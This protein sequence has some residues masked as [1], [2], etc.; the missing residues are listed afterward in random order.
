M[1]E[2]PILGTRALNRA[3]L[4]RQHLLE[5]AT[6]TLEDV[7][8][9][10]GGLQ[11]QQARSGYIGAWT[12]LAGLRRAD[13]TAALNERRLVQ[14]WL[15][16]VTIHTVAAAEYW[17]MAVAVRR[18]RRAW[19][20]RA[21]GKS[22]SEADLRRAAAAVRTELADG[23]L[24]QKQLVARMAERWYPREVT[25][26]AGLWVD[27]VR[28]PPQGTWERPR[29]DLYGLAE[30]W[31]P[32][33]DIAE[34]DARDLLLRRFLGAYGPAAVADASGWTG[35][36]VSEL[37]P[38]VERA[39]LRRF[40]DE[41]GRELLDLPDAQVPDPETPAP[42][43]FIGSFD[44][45]LLIQARRTGVLPEEFRGVVYNTGAPQSFHTF[46]LDGQV[47]GSWRYA[48]G[49]VELTP[50]RSLG[51]AERRELEEEAYRLEAFHADV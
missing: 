14:G 41:A 47:A 31:L 34:H 15:M 33:T 28:V 50:F 16:R 20:A 12:R 1:A 27:L 7:V 39:A 35:L 43:R 18:P 44:A 36:S 2:P 21:W 46:L 49:R 29:A 10:V 4:A 23:P 24:R 37:R 19:W 5:R 26:G 40:R 38:V 9:R 17:P 22:V 25:I 8:E 32:P 42:A 51:T 13:Y 45:M 11:T 3:M 30:D 6:G 48:D